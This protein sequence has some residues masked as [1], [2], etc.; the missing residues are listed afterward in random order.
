MDGPAELI[1][2]FTDTG[3]ELR[4]KLQGSTEQDIDLGNEEYVKKFREKNCVFRFE[5]ITTKN[6]ETLSAF[7]ESVLGENQPTI[8][9]LREMFGVDKINTHR[10]VNKKESSDIFYMNGHQKLD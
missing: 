6:I 3:N 1:K 2:H 9:Y 7:Y 5:D 10:N 4:E 8:D